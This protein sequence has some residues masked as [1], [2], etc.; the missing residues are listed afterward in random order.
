M[1]TSTSL[2]LIDRTP[3]E[4]D[5]VDLS[6]CTSYLAHGRLDALCDYANRALTHAPDNACLWTFLGYACA[7][8][9]KTEAAEQAFRRAATL[10]TSDNTACIAYADCCLLRG[11]TSIAQRLYRDTRRRADLK[12]EHT[13]IEYLLRTIGHHR[14]AALL[15][16]HQ[17]WNHG[18]VAQFYPR[19]YLTPRWTGT[20]LHGRA[21]LIHCADGYGDILLNLRFLQELDLSQDITLDCPCALHSLIS[22]AFPSIKLTRFT[23]PLPQQFDYHLSLLALAGYTGRNSVDIPDSPYLNFSFNEKT[24]ITSMSQ[25]DPRVSVV[26]DRA[27][28]TVARR[29]RIGL[30]WRASA[31]AHNRSLALQDLLPL[32]AT[33]DLVSLQKDVTLEEQ[34]TIQQ[35]DYRI[36]QTELGDFLD[37]ARQIASVDYVVSV[38]T[39]VAHL[40]GG[41]GKRM[42]LLLS[43]RPAPMWHSAAFR[44]RLYPNAECLIVRRRDDQT[45]HRPGYLPSVFPSASCTSLPEISIDILRHRILESVAKK[46]SIF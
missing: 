38:D 40:A 16:D 29:A 28:A 24:Q 36:E 25:N 35:S 42:T 31:Y 45:H 7:F 8:K 4:F 23:E 18:Y 34:Q 5:P 15:T 13:N 10:P 6:L 44:A 46:I 12:H 43:E 1:N 33:V 30:C 11:Q 9:G 41:M 3:L 39:A 2:A 14:D 22:A 20:D 19:G 26:N 17:F 21:L 37:T 32:A 27:A